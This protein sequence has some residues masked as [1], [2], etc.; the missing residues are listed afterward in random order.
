MFDCVIMS[1]QLVERL[2]NEPQ[3]DQLKEAI[4]RYTLTSKGRN[5]LIQAALP[6]ELLKLIE[7]RIYD[8][9]H[10][11]IWKLIRA[12][13]DNPSNQEYFTISSY[14]NVATQLLQQHSEITI[15]DAS[16]AMYDKKVYIELIL[17]CVANSLASNPS[18]RRF[19]WSEWM[20]QRLPINQLM[21]SFHMLP[22][23][24]A[25]LMGIVY[26]CVLETDILQRCDCH[27]ISSLI[28][29]ICVMEPNSSDFDLF[30]TAF[31]RRLLC[32]S[33]G[34]L[35][36]WLKHTADDQ[37]KIA[38]V[39]SEA[40]TT[41]ATIE[42]SEWDALR[43]NLVALSQFIQ[44]LVTLPTSCQSIVDSAEALATLP[45][46]NWLRFDVVL[47]YCRALDHVFELI[48][49]NTDQ[50]DS[51]VEVLVATD[52]D[53]VL[54]ASL[55]ASTGL[56]GAEPLKPGSRKA[57][58]AENDW[59]EFE[60]RVPYEFQSMVVRV[61][62]TTSSLR[63]ESMKR[64]GM[65]GLIF[66]SHMHVSESQPLIREHA[67]MGMRAVTQFEDARMAITALQR[68]E[69]VDREKWAEIGVDLS[70]HEDS[71][72]IRSSRPSDLK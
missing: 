44:T 65:L 15:A 52:M 39:V 68:S 26:Q 10:S 2:R 7:P 4:I 57:A 71:I 12:L 23:S 8:W 41:F 36:S 18:T 34:G 30:R 20:Q 16:D 43:S 45:V 35:Q 31:L 46:S 1:K 37:D 27:E 11:Q 22:D 53:L 40:I 66:M 56:K 64:R 47:S 62:A 21:K 70:E 33:V 9:S 42:L 24:H 32:S 55:R 63:P 67:V 6:D 54:I 13:I 14:W 5:E 49:D 59:T 3:N 60:Q 50:V 38:V 29:T 58:V 17:Q 28:T 48:A 25:I 61:L 69:I 51:F 72:S 19:A